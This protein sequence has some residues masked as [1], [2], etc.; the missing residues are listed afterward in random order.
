VSDLAAYLAAQLGGDVLTKPLS[1][2]ISI[3]RFRGDFRNSVRFPD[4]NIATEIQAAWGELYELIA[5]T[6]EGYWV[7]SDTVTTTASTAFVSLPSDA[8]RVHAIDRL[9]GT[10]YIQLD[11]VGIADRNWFSS[12]A[13][14]PCAY[15]L[16]ARGIDLFPT[17]D[18]VYTLRVTYEPVAPFLDEIP[19]AYYNGWEEYVVYGALIRLTLNEQRTN[20]WQQQLDLARARI[21]RGA[22]QRKAQEPEYLVLRDAWDSDLLRDERWR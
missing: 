8:W 1:E 13:G 2:L 18:A 14:R 22:S 5:E 9:D 16:T 15:R 19:R 20:D 10:D 3:V 12:T 11:Q 21:T 7:T 17:P 4:S 6:H